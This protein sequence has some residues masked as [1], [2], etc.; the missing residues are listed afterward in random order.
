MPPLI[1][2]PKSTSRV[3]IAYSTRMTLFLSGGI[4]L[5]DL[6]CCRV[7]VDVIGKRKE[8]Q[9]HDR[10]PKFFPSECFAVPQS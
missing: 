7:G 2:L 1:Q 4:R 3:L 6:C 8:R 10:Y 5:P 9:H